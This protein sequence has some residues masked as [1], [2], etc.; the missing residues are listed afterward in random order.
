RTLSDYNI[1]K[2]SIPSSLQWHADLCQDSH[3]H[4]LIANCARGG[5]LGHHRQCQGQD[6][7]QPR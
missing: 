1:P 3:R 6:P 4:L 7:R 2:E 5:I